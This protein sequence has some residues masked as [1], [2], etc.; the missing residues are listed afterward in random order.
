MEIENIIYVVIGIGWFVWNTYRKAKAG[1]QTQPKPKRRRQAPVDSEPAAEPF[2][3]LE[4]MILE[5]FGEKKTPEP[6]VV[7]SRKH[8]NQDKFLSHDLKHSHLP[9]NYQMS[10]S[11]MASHRVERQVKRV[12]NEVVEESSLLEEILPNGFDLRQAVI[13]NAVLERPYS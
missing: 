12:E 6:V 10:K 5:Q 2:K 9:D 13:M 1:K 4:D 8:E 3:S 7:E 11:E